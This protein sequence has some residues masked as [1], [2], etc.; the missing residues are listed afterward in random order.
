MGGKPPKRKFTT[1]GRCPDCD[2]KD[3]NILTRQEE[4][5]RWVEHRQCA[6]PKCQAVYQHSYTAAE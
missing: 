1:T 5:G 4:Q 3:F 2:S 6:N